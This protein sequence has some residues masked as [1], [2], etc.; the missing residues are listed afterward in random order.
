MKSWK[1]KKYRRINILVSK[2]KKE[3]RGERKKWRMRNRERERER[4]KGQ[5]ESVSSIKWV[6][7]GCL[8]NS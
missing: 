6:R 4:A 7:C 2:N 1:I 8:R 5:R 3:R